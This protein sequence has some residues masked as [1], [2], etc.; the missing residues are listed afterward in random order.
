MSN[1]QYFICT[2]ALVLSALLLRIAYQLGAEP[3]VHIAGDI[4]DYVRYAWNLGQH[5]VYSSAAIDPDTVP[6]GDSFR[7]PGFPL[8]LLLAMKVSS[9]D[10]G[11]PR[12]AYAMQIV[13]STA[14]VLL[15]ILVAREWIQPGFA[16]L[17]GGLMALWPHHIVFASTLLSETLLGFTIIF[18]IWLSSL[19]ARRKSWRIAALAG[20]A[21]AF[22]ALINPLMLLFPFAV[23][24]MYF[25]KK[26]RRSCAAVLLTFAIVLGAWSIASPDGTDGRTNSHRATINLVQGSWPIY[27]AAWQARH[28]HD[29]AKQLLD[30][31]HAEIDLFAEN[32]RAGMKALGHRL[33]LDPAGYAHW[34]LLKKPYLLWD[35]DIRLGW[36]GVHFLPVTDTPMEKHPILLGSHHAL[37][38]LNPALFVLSLGAV[39]V[40][41][42]LLIR[43]ESIPPAALLVAGLVVYVTA[44]HTILQ[45]EPRYSIPYRPEQ[46]I[47]VAAILAF[48]TD[49]VRARIGPNLKP[50]CTI[51]KTKGTRPFS[52][53]AGSDAQIC[54]NVELNQ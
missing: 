43:G 23:A 44:L 4:N 5:G 6:P 15:T 46:M 17:A 22:A 20:A 42:L 51:S 3:M 41:T 47:L 16:L 21:L 25:T 48:L 50:S 2:V 30:A 32:P 33:W 39:G 8:F 35:W 45:A 7:P 40:I 10:S 12:I 11:W 26:N 52:P 34:Y 24:L 14:T 38:R 54:S 31:I 37:K 1:R 36:G 53:R 27:H 29:E 28:H 18:S 9:F 49:R 13:L 19:A